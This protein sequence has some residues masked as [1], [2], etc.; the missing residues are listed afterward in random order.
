MMKFISNKKN[1]L[2]QVN[3]FCDLE[4]LITKKYQSIADIKKRIV[5]A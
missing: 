3:E 1:N 5:L 4:K 2:Q